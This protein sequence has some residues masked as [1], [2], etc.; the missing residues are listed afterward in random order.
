MDLFDHVVSG[1][2]HILTD[3]IVEALAPSAREDGLVGNV[4]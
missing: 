4:F 3:T 2:S 1:D